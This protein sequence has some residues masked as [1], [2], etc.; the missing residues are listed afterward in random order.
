MNTLQLLELHYPGRRATLK[1]TILAKSLECFNLYGIETTTIEMIKNECDT[2]VGAI[3]HHFGNK[4]GIVSALF[5][6]ALKDQFEKRNIYFKNANTLQDFTHA[7]V[8]SYIDWIND[9]PDFSK[10][11]LS[12]KYHVNVSSYS[13]QLK[14]LNSSRNRQIFSSLENFIHAKDMKKLPM[15]LI[16]SLIIGSTENYTRAW[17]AQKVQT[18]PVVYKKELAH[19][20][21]ESV[22]MFFC[23]S[24]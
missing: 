8:Y 5:F 12:A 15:D 17:L 7:I 1:R 6:L 2:S 18:S 22:K 3:Y 20:A 19:S 21:W 24:K 4:E 9:Y 16:F 13:D 11:M 10:F 14:D 23:D